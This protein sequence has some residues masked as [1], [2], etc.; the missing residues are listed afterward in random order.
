MQAA[1]TVHVGVILVQCPLLISCRM[2]VWSVLGVAHVADGVHIPLTHV[3]CMHAVPRLSP[4]HAS[5]VCPSICCI[6]AA[7]QC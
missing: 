4:D 1:Q 7:A 3:L 2:P 5:I 6:W